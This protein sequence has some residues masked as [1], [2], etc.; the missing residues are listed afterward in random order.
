MNLVH[1]GGGGSLSADTDIKPYKFFR[2]ELS[3]YAGILLRG[4][5][6]VVPNS[7]QKRILMLAHESRVVTVWTKQLL[8]SKYFSVGMDKA[9]E[10]MIKDCPAC[11]ASRLLSNNTAGA[12]AKRTVA[13]MSSRHR[14]ANR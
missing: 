7:L 4:S 12:V 6:I 8:R 2:E 10:S 13:K 3:V 14:R 5:R 1:A 9:I 11:A